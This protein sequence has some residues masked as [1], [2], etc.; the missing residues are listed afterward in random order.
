MGRINRTTRRKSKLMKGRRRR[1]VLA[2]VF[3]MLSSV[4]I[5]SFAASSNTP[6]EE[7]V[8]VNLKSDGS[9][10]GIY[11]IN[12]FDL[13]QDG[14]IIDYGDYT[15]FRQLTAWEGFQR[16]EDC[17]T[18]DAKAGKLYYEG[19]LKDE[20]IPWLFNIKYFLNG[21]EYAGDEIGGRSGALEI[22]ISIKENG[23]SVDGFFKNFTLQTTLK[24]D[25]SKAKDIVAPGGTVANAGKYKQIVF[26]SFPGKGGDLSVKASVTDFEMEGISINAVSMEMDFEFEDDPDLTARLS[27]L[28]D[29]FSKLDDG[30]VKLKDGAKDLKEGTKDFKEG[31]AKLNDGVIELAEGTGQL[32]DSTKEMLNGVKEL[33]DGVKD[34]AKG[35]K[36][37]KDGAKEL[38]KGAKKLLSA[39][40]DLYG[41]ARDLS[42]GLSQLASKNGELVGGAGQI[43][44]LMID[45]ANE[46]I[47]GGGLTVNTYESDLNGILTPMEEAAQSSIVSDSEIMNLIATSASAI[48]LGEIM[49]ENPDATPE[50]INDIISG[51][52]G[53]V[54][55]GLKITALVQ[56]EIQQILSA[57]PDY[58]AVYTL[59]EQL[60]GYENFYMGLKSYANGV[61]DLAF[62]AGSLLSGM[63]DWRNGFADFRDGIGELYD[64]TVKL[65]DGVIELKDGT[66][67]LLDGTIELNDGV[68][69]LNDGAIK[70]KDG[71]IELFDGAIELHDGAVE[72]YDGSVKMAKGTMEFKD[73]TKNMEKELKDTIKEKIDTMLGRNFKAKSFVSEKNTS[74]SSVQFVMHTGGISLPELEKP[75][76]EPEPE[77]TLIDRLLALF[78]IKK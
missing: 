50:E 69:E 8:Y 34:L 12:S 4:F 13:D 10:E 45:G 22:T 16:E 44:Q 58:I 68:V 23:E 51:P 21:I 5:P 59:K 53:Q 32:N 57:N 38:D 67:R 55:I 31:V 61:S 33:N 24:F 77:L 41:G 65:N 52:D 47:P 15:A 62:G 2:I 3:L 72:F 49:T 39:A 75:I 26:T 17:I 29:G 30:A 60:K 54:R 25:S 14:R 74:V 66:A 76:E 6:K 64:G 7:V 63:R 36:E 18:I 78:K 37:I 9:V 43:F 48:V 56:N 42:G 35:T 40:N 27:E 70:L 11:V 46:K 73:K 20:A 71:V 1:L 28:R 19:K